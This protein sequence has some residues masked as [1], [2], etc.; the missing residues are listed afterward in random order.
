MENNNVTRPYRGL[1]TDNSPQDQ[2]KGTHRFGLNGVRESENGDEN[3]VSN[4]EANE[5]CAVFPEGYIPIGKEY[6]GNGQSAVFLA[7]SDET[8][9]EIGI[10]DD[11]CNY[12]THVNADL[13]FK[14]SKQIDE[15]SRS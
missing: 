13:G 11:E 3:F 9:S 8:L 6:I 12:E 4:E 10:V 7:K 15:T 2:P 1:H 14:V 5:E